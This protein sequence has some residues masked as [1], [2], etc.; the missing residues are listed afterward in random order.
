MAGYRRAAGF[1]FCAADRPLMK[2]HH[3]I[4]IFIEAFSTLYYQAEEAY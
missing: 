2:V 1:D 3:F 4:S